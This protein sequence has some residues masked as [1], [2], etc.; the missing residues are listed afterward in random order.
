ML[1]I[2]SHSYIKEWCSY[3]HIHLVFFNRKNLLSIY[4]WRRDSWLKEEQRGH[5]LA[6]DLSGRYS[7][8]KAYIPRGLSLGITDYCLT[9]LYKQGTESTLRS[10]RR[11][12]MSLFFPYSISTTETG[13][14]ILQKQPLMSSFYVQKD[15]WI[16]TISL[17]QLWDK[18]H[19]QTLHGRNCDIF[20]SFPFSIMWT[21]SR[22]EPKLI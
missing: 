19:Q 17:F 9:L 3:C 11:K 18:M 2:F 5:R 16:N 1:V 20:S 10:R 15:Q 12:C 14:Y 7:P 22:S 13:K 6:W 21:F 4:K 8:L